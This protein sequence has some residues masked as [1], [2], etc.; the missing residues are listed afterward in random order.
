MVI[1]AMLLFALAPASVLAQQ[2][3]VSTGQ[4]GSVTGRAIMERVDEAQYAESSRTKMSMHIFDSIHSDESR[5]YYIQSLS[6][7]GDEENFMEFVAPRSIKGMKILS[8]DEEVRVYFPS[9]GRVRRITGSGKSGS[10]GGLGGDFSYE[11]MSGGDRVE[12]YDFTLL[13]QSEDMWK[14]EAV[15]TDEDISYSRVI[16]FIDR[17]KL[18]PVKIEYYSEEDGHSK[19]MTADR[20]EKISGRYSPML[21]TMENH[22]DQKK[23]V[24]KVHET[25]FDVDPPQRYFNPSRF[26]R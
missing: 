17:E 8:L 7:K 14:I 26:Y 2:S 16:F 9:T 11:D 12:D 3:G 4:S 23:T 15:P 1:G 21:I 10:V 18:L 24:I 22:E 19:T 25:A 20:I 13:S 6:R 5:D